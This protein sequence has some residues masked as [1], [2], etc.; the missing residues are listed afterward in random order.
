[1]ADA[2]RAYTSEYNFSYPAFE[3]EKVRRT[4]KRPEQEQPV[5]VKK[6]E[7]LLNAKNLRTIFLALFLIGVMLVGIVLVNAQAAKL[8]YSINQ[9]KNQND[10]LENEITMLEVKLDSSTS[11]EQLEKVGTKSLGMFYPSGSS[12][13]DLSLVATPDTSLAETIKQKAYS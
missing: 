8:Q 1:M 9:L 3:P 4:R 10:I 7:E 2:R 11:I 13:V 5:E 6:K 12:R